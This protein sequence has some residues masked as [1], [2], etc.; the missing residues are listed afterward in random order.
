MSHQPPPGNSYRPQAAAQSHG[1]NTDP[2]ETRSRISG[3]H[4]NVSQQPNSQ[5]PP[6]SHGGDTDPNEV[7]R[8]LGG[9]HHVPGQ[10][11]TH[12]Q[13]GQQSSS[14][15]YNNTQAA[16]SAV[17]YSTG[18]SPNISR[19][20]SQQ[21][22]Y[23]SMNQQP[24]GPVQNQQPQPGQQLILNSAHYV[25]VSSPMQAFSAGG[26]ELITEFILSKFLPKES[27]HLRTMYQ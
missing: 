1:G 3:G 4:Q 9:G 11:N 19:T 5:R 10:S 18:S 14:S 27:N 15:Q 26:K 6:H 7:R 17:Q 8:Q 23:Q 16:S 24:H 13:T 21:Q 25:S 2:N 20:S 12:P 22:A